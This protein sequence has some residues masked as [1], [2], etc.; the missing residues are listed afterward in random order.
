M[1]TQT[2]IKN[3]ASTSEYHVNPPIKRQCSEATREKIRKALTGHKVSEVTKAKL[4][5]ATIRQHSEGRVVKMSA[6]ARAI[7]S[8]RMKEYMRSGKINPHRPC[9]ESVKEKLR[10]RKLSKEHVE[11]IRFHALKQAKEG[12]MNIDG[13]KLGSP[14]G[15]PKMWEKVR[16]SNGFGRGKRGRLDHAKACAWRVR[17]PNGLEYEFTNAREWCRKNESLFVEYN[18]NSRYPL[19]LRAAN[20]FSKLSSSAGNLCSWHGWT[21]I[22]WFEMRDW[23]ERKQLPQNEAND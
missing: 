8:E 22:A 12:R 14:I 15:L 6:E 10:A 23:L 13:L 7:Q 3:T 1:E 4:R 2:E 16:G 17:C 21:L 20:G 18:P 19:W 9:P 11:S 5:A